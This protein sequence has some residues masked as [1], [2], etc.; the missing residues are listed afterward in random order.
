MVHRSRNMQ[1]FPIKCPCNKAV[2][3]YIIPRGN[4]RPT[5][6]NR[7]VFTAEFIIRSTCCCHHY[8]H[9]QELKIYTDGC[10]LWYL[11][12]FQNPHLKYLNYTK[13]MTKNSTISQVLLT[14]SDTHSQISS[15]WDIVLLFVMFL[16]QFKYFRGDI[17]TV[18]STT[19]SN[20]LYKS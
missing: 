7:L 3:D 12:L 17:G 11:A 15:T 10:C 13:N 9:H 5:R 8:V 2:L 6:C 19:G 1:L 20:H 16:V 14:I 18:P 4:K